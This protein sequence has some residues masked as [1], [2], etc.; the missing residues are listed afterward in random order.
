MPRHPINPT[1]MGS[2]VPEGLPLTA[3]LWNDCSAMLAGIFTLMLMQGASCDRAATAISQDATAHARALD[4]DG[5]V[6]QFERASKLGCR[7][8]ELA[9]LYL[10]ALQTA[11]AAYR[12]GGD[13]MT[14]APVVAAAAGL[15]RWSDASP[16]AA[17]ARSVLLAAIAAAQSE[18]DD[19]QL[20]LGHA[21]ELERRLF[22]SGEAGAPG[23]TAHEVAGDLWL[24][25][26]RFDAARAAYSAAA[27]LVGTTPRVLLG[28]ARSAQRL[29]DTAGACRSY[30]MFLDSVTPGLP[31]GRAGGPYVPAESAEARAFVAA[32]CGGA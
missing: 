25:V 29:Q 6:A 10:R 30:R 19:V 22:A 12:S 20:L 15:E 11:R 5:A 28:L 17:V 16:R 9:V 7:D 8:A 4:G 31:Q 14:L 13:A 27:E 24:Q 26:H 3:R 2:S 1:L 32:N 21:L 18:R 23:I